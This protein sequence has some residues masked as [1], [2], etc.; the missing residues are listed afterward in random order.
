MSSAHPDKDVRIFYKECVSLANNFQPEG[1]KVEVHLILAGVKERIEQGVHIHSVEHH[2]GSRIKR[3]WTTV[4]KVY[5]KARELNGDIY[6]FHDPELL[7]IAPKLK[8]AGK[9]VIY[10]AHEDL[11]RQLMGKSYL[12]FK[13]QISSF[14]EKYENGIVKKLDAVATA[15]PFIR[16][17]FLKIHPAAV[18]INNFPLENEIEV[19]HEKTERENYVCF[20]GGISKIRGT[21]E[22]ADAMGLV[23]SELYLAGGIPE[24]LKGE[25]VSSTGWTNVKDLGFIDRK[26]ALE[27]K[28]KALAGIVTFLP[29]PNHV[30]AQ[31]NK[32]F[33]YMA[34]GLPVI[35]S[36]FPLWKEIIVDNHCGICVDPENPQEIAKAI[37]YLQ[38]HPEEVE[39]MGENGK[40][41]VAEKYNWKA[42]EKKLFR[43]YERLIAQK[44]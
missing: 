17:R 29:L 24:S 14:F 3:M 6:H 5:T 20:I 15:T 11:P 1:Y 43:L 31:P 42:E 34:S 28:K 36:H 18:D 21:V 19:I 33:E 23:K 13:D 32:I 8:R 27:I 22:L 41:I 16:D 44:K 12:R 35:G 9:I 26:T 37:E 4:N 38:N 7:R 10:D 30:N 2:G 40:R 39:K 25:L